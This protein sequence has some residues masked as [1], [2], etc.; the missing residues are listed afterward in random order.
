M[1]RRDRELKGEVG[2]TGQGLRGLKD[3]KGGNE[4]RN[5]RKNM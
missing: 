5:T 4:T 1:R 3:K 2:G